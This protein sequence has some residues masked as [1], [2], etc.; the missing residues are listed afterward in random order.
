MPPVD[1][2]P[3]TSIEAAPMLPVDPGGSGAAPGPPPVGG[4]TAVDVSVLPSS[5]PNEV[6]RGHVSLWVVQ[7]LF[8]LFPVFGLVAFQA[9]SPSAVAAWR[10]IVGSLVLVA[11]AVRMHGRAAIPPRREVPR[12]IFGSWMGVGLN[13]LLF[14]EG[15]SRSTAVH[16]GLL[17]TLIPVFTV[18]VAILARQERFS[19]QVAL[20]ILVA[21][22]GKGVLFFY[23][24][25]E[26]GAPPGQT[27]GNLMM[28]GNAFCYASYLV[29]MRPLAQRHPPVA[30]LAWMYVGSLAF[31]PYFMLQVPLIPAE[32]SGPAL[33]SLLYVLL[34]PTLLAYLLN[35]Y[36]LARVSASTT[37][38]YIYLQPLIS[39]AGGVLVL[40]EKIGG[41]VFVAALLLFAGVG[42]VVLRPPSQAAPRVR[43][44]PES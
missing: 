4:G 43:P 33:R 37:A 29:M 38:V 18:L 13:Q 44:Q 31:L 21:A 34:A 6:L 32:V 26:S 30:L 7:V 19:I 1:P 28:V 25:D 17:V 36:A 40:N 22:A 15:L 3:E 11:L 8:G 20:G 12:L 27:L 39:A 5:G 42:L 16:A 9:F 2:T 35:T 10:L 23:G 14:L 24:H 41:H